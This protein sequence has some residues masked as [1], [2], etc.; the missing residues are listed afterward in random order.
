MEKKIA[1]RQGREELIKKG[2]L[3]L[4]E[5]GKWH[6]LCRGRSSPWAQEARGTAWM[7]AEPGVC[8]R[9]LDLCVVGVSHLGKFPSRDPLGSAWGL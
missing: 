4:M 5:Q 8:A 7:W 2:L 9:R 1:G 3:E 6:R